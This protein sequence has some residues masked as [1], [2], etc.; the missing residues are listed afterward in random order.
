MLKDELSRVIIVFGVFAERS[1]RTVISLFPHK[2]IGFIILLISFSLVIGCTSIPTMHTPIRMTAT[3]TN[4]NTPTPTVSAISPPSLKPDSTSTAL[5]QL[6]TAVPYLPGLAFQLETSPFSNEIEDAIFTIRSDGTELSR[7]VEEPR[8]TFYPKWSP[9]GRRIAFL[10]LNP[11][12]FNYQLYI[13]EYETGE[14][15]IVPTDH[16]GYFAWATDSRMI[17]Y[18]EEVDSLY[19]YQNFTP[20]K[21]NLIDIFDFQPQLLYEAPWRVLDIEGSPTGNSFLV[22]SSLQDG[23]RSLYLIDLDGNIIDLMPEGDIIRYMAWHPNGRQ[24][25]YSSY[26]NSIEKTVIRVIDL[27][28]MDEY[29]LFSTEESTSEPLWSPSGDLIAYNRFHDSVSYI[30]YITDLRS[31]NTW[32]ISGRGD[33]CHTPLWSSDGNYLAFVCNTDNFQEN[34]S[35]LIVYSLLDQT[36]KTIVADRVSSNRISWQ[37]GP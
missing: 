12:S 36:M 33:N 22:L 28:D 32:P 9:D 20:S 24:I 18:S 6:S 8:E 17:A 3:R 4:Y 30:V 21:I 29:V 19:Y 7:L 1:L 31:G 35:R 5:I 13:M 25:A 34:G 27:N 14:I 16:V 10:G 2:R 15:N 11:I 37:P 23:P 26:E